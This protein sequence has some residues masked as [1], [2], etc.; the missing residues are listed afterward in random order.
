MRMEIIETEHNVFS[1]RVN[2]MVADRLT[3]DEALGVV[4]SALFSDQPIF[5]KPYKEWVEWCES[6]NLIDRKDQKLLQ[7]RVK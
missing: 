3:K 6:V 4:A 7:E 1:V 2:D 5:E